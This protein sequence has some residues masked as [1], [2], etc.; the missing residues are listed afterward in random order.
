MPP[1]LF[2]DISKMKSKGTIK[3]E[4]ALFNAQ[5]ELFIIAKPILAA[6]IELRELG[7]AVK[8][9]R[10]IL[11]VSLRGIY[12][13]S[14]RISTAHRENVRFFIQRSSCRISLFLPPEKCC[15]TRILINL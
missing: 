12:S 15:L 9:S 2:K 13:V 1:K 14:I 7:C 5:T 3:T 10:E 8:K 6:L 11:S 4:K